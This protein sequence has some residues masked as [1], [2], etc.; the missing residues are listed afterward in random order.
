MS[1]MTELKAFVEELD[2]T[3]FVQATQ[4]IVVK[5]LD[6]KPDEVTMSAKFVD[7]LGA[8]SLDITE[9]LMALEEEYNIE[10]DD[11]A[12]DIQT[13]GQAVKYIVDKRYDAKKKEVEGDAEALQFLEA[14]CAKLKAKI[15]ASG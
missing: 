13:V 4:E 12:N 8:D 15:D 3:D 10:I 6:R 14:E 5:Q 11:E 9:L 1:D 7:D 2:Q